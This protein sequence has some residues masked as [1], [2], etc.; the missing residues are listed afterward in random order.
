MNYEQLTQV[1]KLAD[2]EQIKNR[3]TL[4]GYRD[5]EKD[6]KLNSVSFVTIAQSSIEDTEQYLSKDK[7]YCF[8]G[9]R[10][11]NNDV[12]FGIHIVFCN[13]ILIEHMKD[14]FQ[15]LIWIIGFCIFRICTVRIHKIVPVVKCLAVYPSPVDEICQNITENLWKMIETV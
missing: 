11:I 10:S 3:M 14:N 8:D 12:A 15:I 6:E 7:Q 13:I 2:R 5:I 4:L 9:H 1:V